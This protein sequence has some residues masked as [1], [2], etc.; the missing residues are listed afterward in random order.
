MSV[1]KEVVKKNLLSI[2]FIV[3]LIYPVPAFAGPAL[4]TVKGYTDQVLDVLRDPALKS[5]AARKTKKDK[6]RA[7]S[8]KMFDYTELSKRTL[9]INWKRL[10]PEQQKEF[11]SLYTS[12]LG[13]AYADKILSY[14][15]EKITLTKE[16]SL[17]AKTVE[18]QSTVL[19][20]N[21][22]VPIYYRMILKDDGTWRVYD[23]VVEGVSLSNNYRTQFKDILSNNPPEALLETLRKKVG[24]G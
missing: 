15:D 7:I 2:I 3:C 5:E 12:L 11:I 14:S 9:T 13:A 10:S 24:K 4:D 20:K 19:S 18:V 16:V 8:E 6:L 1:K 17:S 23:V 21:T 22:E